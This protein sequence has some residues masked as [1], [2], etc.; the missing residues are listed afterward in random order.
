MSVCSKSW[1]TLCDALLQAQEP[2][3]IKL[4]EMTDIYEICTEINFHDHNL[5]NLKVACHCQVQ[6]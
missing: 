4:I 2:S 3:M 1:C 5:N 6:S